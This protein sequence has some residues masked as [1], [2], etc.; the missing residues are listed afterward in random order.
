MADEALEGLL[1]DV[2]SLRELAAHRG[3][4]VL[5]KHAAKQAEV[6]L[7]AM[8]SAPT[9]EALLTATQ[10][11]LLFHDLKDMPLQLEAVYRR[12]AETRQS[13]KR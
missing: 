1:E 12:Q 7:A 11:F 5:C 6:K 10:Q 8:R 2:Q 13:V 4:E 9:Q 3:W